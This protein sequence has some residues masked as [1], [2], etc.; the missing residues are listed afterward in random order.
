MSARVPWTSLRQES[1]ELL[2][3]IILAHHVER[4]LAIIG[5]T[6]GGQVVGHGLAGWVHV[7]FD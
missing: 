1:L 6:R 4:A 2:G 3:V 7:A 5:K